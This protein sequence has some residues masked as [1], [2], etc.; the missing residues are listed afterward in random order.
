MKIFETHDQTAATSFIS[1]EKC[2][3]EKFWRKYPDFVWSLDMFLN[4]SKKNKEN[5][6]KILAT[7]SIFNQIRE[8][9]MFQNFVVFIF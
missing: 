7:N 4:Y 1:L 8:A 3:N 6:I 2:E 5:V 9:E